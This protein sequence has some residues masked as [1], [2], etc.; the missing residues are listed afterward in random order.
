MHDGGSHTPPKGKMERATPGEDS[1][2][3]S[4][5]KYEEGKGA[6]QKS[7]ANTVG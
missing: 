2:R 5:N 7:Q 6:G 4:K 1:S 3:E